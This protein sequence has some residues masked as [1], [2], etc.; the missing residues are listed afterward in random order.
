MKLTLR[1]FKKAAK[2]HA[3]QTGKPLSTAQ[4]EIAVLLGFPS[5]HAVIQRLGSPSPSPSPAHAQLTRSSARQTST[6]PQ[7]VPVCAEAPP[8]DSRA[9]RAIPPKYFI[10]G[11]ALFFALVIP[12]FLTVSTNTLWG[13][14][15]EGSARKAGRGGATSSNSPAAIPSFKRSVSVEINTQGSVEQATR[16]MMSACQAPCKVL[17][18][19][20]IIHPTIEQSSAS[21]WVPSASEAAFAR[22]LAALGPAVS[23]RADTEDMSGLNPLS[24]EQQV[25]LLVYRDK[26]RVM[27][28]QAR[29]PQNVFDIQKE[30]K[31]TQERLDSSSAAR[32]LLETQATAVRFDVKI[33]KTRPRLGKFEKIAEEMKESFILGFGVLTTIL[34]FLISFA[35]AGAMLWLGY[36][37]I[38]SWLERRNLAV[39]G[40][41]A[42]GQNEH[43]TQAPRPPKPTQTQQEAGPDAV[44]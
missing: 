5:F 23:R 4:E 3:A 17:S 24:S 16:A 8:T 25:N 42:L 2:R 29:A 13:S 1:S 40:K 44:P 32:A 41:T 11:A 33:E 35:V 27:L 43:N 10:G 19:N 38:E 6:P 39:K 14:A 26:L 7:T 20:T 15:P 21:F 22:S 36:L 12:S 34:S 37:P 9:W 28:N 30:L 18:Q 31:E